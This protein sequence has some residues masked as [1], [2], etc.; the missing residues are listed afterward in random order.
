MLLVLEKGL[1]TNAVSDWSKLVDSINNNISGLNTLIGECEN[2]L[3][4]SE[5]GINKVKKL[6]NDFKVLKF[7]VSKTRPVSGNNILTNNKDMNK[8]L[9]IEKITK[10]ED[11]DANTWNKL[12]INVIGPSDYVKHNSNYYV[13]DNE[14]IF[15]NYK[16]LF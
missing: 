5:N 11:I 14:K 16:R 3:I 10:N 12:N 1:I 8:T 4:Y 2:N 13:I 6:A 9:M 15:R 7:K